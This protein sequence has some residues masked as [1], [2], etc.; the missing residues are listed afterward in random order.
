MFKKILVAVDGSD[1]SMRALDFAAQLSA[2][3]Q[4]ELTVLT[5]VPHLPPLMVEDI[6]P[7]YI[8]RYQDELETSYIKLLN[9]T[10]K[11]LKEKHP[12]LNTVPIV[13]QGKP[14][15]IIVQVSRDREVDLI[16]IGNR[17]IGGIA[18]WMLGSVSRQVVES[19]TVPV[20]VVKDEQFCNVP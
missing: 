10:A 11:K 13:M 12:T 9:E 7:E 14:A 19:C 20:L 4:A 6:T 5:I 8:P 15:K 1:P 3:N 17:G 2:E 16:V 18:T